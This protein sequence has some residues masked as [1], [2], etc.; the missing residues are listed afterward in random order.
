MISRY[1]FGSMIETDAV[2]HKPPI[3]TDR[4]SKLSV[5]EASMSLSLHLH[6]KDV[7]YGLGENVR[8]INKR[9]WLYRSKT[10]DEPDHSET[11]NSLY[12][13]HNFI[14]IDTDEPFALFFDYAG[15]ITFDIGFTHL[16]EMKISLSDW[17]FDLYL[18]EGGDKIELVR[19]FRKLIGK[20][21]IPPKWAF[22]YGQSRWSYHDA[23]EV[24]TV[25][26]K[27]RDAKVPLDMVYL[28]ID[29]M[30]GY[31][32]F[33]VNEAAFGD[34][35]VFTAEMRRENIHLI[36]IID[37]GIKQENGYRVY[38]EGLEKG[39]F[40]VKEDGSPFIAAVWPGKSVFAD[41]MNPE[42]RAWFGEQYRVLVD[43]GIEGFWNDMNEPSIFYTED[44]LKSVFAEISEMQG[45]NM[46]VERFWHFQ[47]I[48]NGLTG[49]EE[50]YRCF[51][52]RYKGELI[53]HD[54]VHN[55]FGYFLTRGASEALCGMMPDRRYLLISRTSS[56]GMHR[57]SGVWMGDNR[58][59]WSH[60][61]LNMQMLPSLNMIG[62]LYTGCDLGGLTC[63]VT[64]DLMLRW[65]A[66]GIFYPLMRNHSAINTRRQEFYEFDLTDAFRS[67]IS[68]R[69]R[70]IP[71]LYS[72]YMKAALRDEMMF[73]PLAFDY[74]EDEHA[75]TVEDQ[76]MLGRELMIAPVYRQNADGRYVYLPEDM[77]LLR[78]RVDGSMEEEVLEKGHHYVKVPLT[79]VVF[80]LR[81]G[82]MLPLAEAAQHS[83]AV[84][85]NKLSFIKFGDQNMTY[86]LYDDDGCSVSACDEKHF[87]I[88]GD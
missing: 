30:D 62:F 71:Y 66:M 6:E 48:V 7:V 1:A 38:E 39:Y 78:F 47:S 51:Y 63:D 86:E 4:F 3:R 88:I 17:N 20:S 31:K 60:L 85:F 43:K 14:L 72:E 12:A 50:D 2:L 57:Y 11:R 83:G 82:K 27:H 70:L 49:N 41:I 45:E 54:R 25:V 68:L 81:R 84:D 34:L 77:K 24:R 44:R 65:L 35:S 21:Y 33:T 18:I 26:R 37:A 55:L 64:E 59:W 73:R 28:D 40:C 80:F 56:I 79:D 9:G 76:L 15:I 36:P 87:R 74:P 5:N 8:G 32:D 42:A 61:L 13:A 19:Q 69:Y 23:D 52:H 10:V 53:R 67:I 58:S 16:D 22:G 75:S 46:G 29:Y